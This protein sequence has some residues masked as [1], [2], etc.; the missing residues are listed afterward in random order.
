MRI[1]AL[2]VV[3]GLLVMACTGGT[4]TTTDNGVPTDENKVADKVAKDSG[5]SASAEFL[6]LLGA[7]AN[8]EWKVAYTIANTDSEGETATMQLT[9]YMKTE[10]KI[11]MDMMAAG[12]E[13][14]TFMVNGVATVCSKISGS[15][16]CFKMDTDQQEEQ[17]PASERYET[18]I[19]EN[20][21]DYGIVADGTKQVAGVTATCFKITQNADNVEARYCFKDSVPLYIYTKSP[22]FTSEMTATSYSKSVSDSDF[23]PPAE[24]KDINALVGGLG[25][26]AGSTAD[27]CSYCDMVPSD[28]KADCLANC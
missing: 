25:G 16:N 15:W 14:Q 27:P 23:V 3:L 21:S 17:T 18:Q 2:M 22:D 9:Q 5:S 26:G 8:L 19:E 24:A 12:T 4:G 7:K 20:P 11:R 1:L 6:K 10:K 13:S 28:A